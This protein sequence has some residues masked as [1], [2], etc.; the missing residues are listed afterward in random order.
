MELKCRDF[1][2]GG[3]AGSFPGVFIIPL[4][5]VISSAPKAYFFVKLNFGENLFCRCF[6]TFE[7]DKV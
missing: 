1:L 3:E 4:G 7:A 5:A 2:V 6:L